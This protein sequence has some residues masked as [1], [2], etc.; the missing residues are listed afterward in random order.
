MPRSRSSLRTRPCGPA[1]ER[2]LRLLDAQGIDL[3]LLSPRPV[4]MMHWERQFLVDQWTRVT[5]DL[6]AR[7]CKLHPD[8]FQGVAQLPQTRG[9][10]MVRCADE[11]ERCATEHGFVGAILNPDPGGGPRLARRQ[12]PRIGIRCTSAPRSST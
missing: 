10:D 11:L 12:R 6:I 8:R 5:N 1:L 2:H 9:C 4:A 7:Q 3:Q